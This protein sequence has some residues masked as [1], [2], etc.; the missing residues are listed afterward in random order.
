MC[1]QREIL[2]NGGGVLTSPVRA[3][4]RKGGG[5]FDQCRKRQVSCFNDAPSD[6]L[7]MDIPVSNFSRAKPRRG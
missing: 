5:H 4:A 1:W 6:A 7:G 2:H 3:L